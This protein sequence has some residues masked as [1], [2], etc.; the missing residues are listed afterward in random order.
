MYRGTRHWI[1]GNA[2]RDEDK[3]HTRAAVDGS[4]KE[5]GDDPSEEGDVPTGR[6]IG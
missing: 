2:G 4:Q 3:R 6:G 5:A 1:G